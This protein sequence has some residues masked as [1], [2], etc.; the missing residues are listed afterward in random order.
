[1]R[2]LAISDFHISKNKP[3]NRKESNY[4]IEAV[5]PK[6]DFI[7]YTFHKNHCDFILCGGD[8]LDIPIVPD[9]IKSYFIEQDNCIITT[10][11]Q[12]CLSSRLLTDDCSISLLEKA[13]CVK[14]LSERIGMQQTNL[15]SDFSSG[16]FP[17]HVYGCGY[18]E[19][20]PEINNPNVFNILLIHILVSDKDYWA[21]NVNWTSTRQLFRKTKF[22]LIITGDHHKTITAQKGDRWILN[23]G[24]M[25]RKN[26]DQNE[27]EP[28]FFIVDVDENKKVDVK[29]IFIPCNPFD[30]IMKVSEHAR[31]KEIKYDMANWKNELSRKDIKIELNFTKALLNEADECEDGV[32][33]FVEECIEEG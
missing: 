31:K 28:C 26:V 33:D 18:E 27:H 11:G 19:K 22:D 29:Q 6:L 17:C 32:K 2:F 7:F 9:S 14:I 15:I 13:G 12:H 21:G 23:S 8:I 25:M 3:I 24:S 1:M 4:W 5:K 16:P 30:D 20:I 10:L